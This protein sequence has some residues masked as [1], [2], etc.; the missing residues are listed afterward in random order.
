M[1][2]A[3]ARGIQAPQIYEALQAAKT[4]VAKYKDDAEWANSLQELARDDPEEFFD[5]VVEE[6]IPVEKLASWVHAKYHEFSKLAA[7]RPEER[8]RE[9]RAKEAD[10]LLRERA[11]SEEVRKKAEE[12]Q[13][14]ARVEQEK[15]KFASWQHKE[16]QK[17]EAKLPEAAR[18]SLDRYFRMVA[19]S[20]EDYLDSGKD[21]GYGHM[22]RDLADLLN[23]LVV[24]SQ[25]P[26]QAKRE[27]ANNNRARNEAEKEK[28]RGMVNEQPQQK[29]MSKDDVWNNATR[30][31]I[32]AARE[33]KRR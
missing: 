25:S 15:V 4:D 2:V 17:W 12:A 29:R 9:L 24:N 16:R 33:I 8:Q 7:M 13:A 19:L 21:Y 26:V 1:D 22:T 10:K 18:A 3:L 6:L 27:E 23:P 32:N 11:H 30:M 31:A 20:A 5:H 28:L 14:Q